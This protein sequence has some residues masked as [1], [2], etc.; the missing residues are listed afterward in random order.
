MTNQY[1]NDRELHLGSADVRIALY[2]DALATYETAQSVGMLDGCAFKV[3]GETSTVET[4]NADDIDFG[5]TKQQAEISAS[6]WKNLDL[7][8]LYKLIGG[9]GSLTTIAASSPTSVTDE[10]LLMTGSEPQTLAH[11]SAEPS[12]CSSIVVSDVTGETTYV[13][14]TDYA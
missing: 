8:V 2:D 6:A 12:G 11:R 10:G 9:M 13:A 14:D 1:V 3:T 7:D 4:D 5:M